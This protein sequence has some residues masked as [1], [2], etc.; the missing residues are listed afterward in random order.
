MRIVVL[1]AA[2]LVV[3]L[4]AALGWQHLR[5]LK[6]RRQIVQDRQPLFHSAGC[7]HVVTFVAVPEGSDVIEEVRKLRGDLESDG[8][9]ELVWAGRVALTALE[10]E[11]IAPA[12]WS[13]VLLVQY[14][15][16]QAYDAAV[17]SP[18]YRIALD[19]FTRTYSHGLERP[20]GLNLGIPFLLLALRAGQIVSRAPSH[21]PFVPASAEEQDARTAERGARLEQLRRLKPLSEDALVVVNLLKQGTPEQ[22]AA[23]AGYG[24]RM[25]GLFAEGAH[26]PMHIG[27]AVTLE[28]DAEFDRVAIVYYPGVEYFIDMARSSFFNGIVGG[29]QPGDTLAVPTVPITDRL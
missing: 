24:R 23:D 4:V 28:G 7:F 5:Y 2:L 19:R 27:R 22:R 16:R 11:Q 20:R 8:Q 26:G 12:P 6:T 25:A 29:K 18:G 1:V 9:A 3:T 21:Y 13:A 14:P 15:S 10:S 17:A